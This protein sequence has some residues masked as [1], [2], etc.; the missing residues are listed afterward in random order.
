MQMKEEEEEEEEED[1]KNV[2]LLNSQPPPPHFSPSSGCHPN[3]GGGLLTPHKYNRGEYAQSHIECF[4]FLQL[5]LF[6][7]G[8]FFVFRQSWGWL[9]HSNPQ[10]F[11]SPFQN[12]R[13]I[14]PSKVF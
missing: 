7:L 9:Y 2:D 14:F 5:V 10:L 3:N 6:F 12:F 1:K 13:L 4:F 11:F 8:L